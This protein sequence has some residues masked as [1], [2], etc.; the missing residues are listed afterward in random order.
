MKPQRLFSTAVPVFQRAVVKRPPLRIRPPIPPTVNN[1]EVSRDHPLWQFFHD[2]KYLR[3]YEDLDK[4]G[5]PWS[6]PELRK[7]SFDDLH[8]LWYTCLKERNILAREIQV[9]NAE[10]DQIDSEFLNHSD[11]VRETMWRIR[12][13]L[14]ERYHAQSNARERLFENE[15]KLLDEF[16]EFYLKGTKDEESEIQEALTRLQYALFGI[17]EVIEENKV[18]KHFIKGLK[19][20]AN[21]KINRYAT[22]KSILPIQDAGEAFIIFHA[23][24]NTESIK[25]S[26]EA[27]LK[28]RADGISIDKYSE[29]DTIKEYLRR[30]L[31][32]E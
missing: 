1:I 29:I 27:V 6:I 11:Q 23:E 14:S 25:E 32:S 21:L 7:K 15:E 30:V 12:H 28:L 2:G 26:I 13:V 16:T 17:S 4:A 20:I 8:S 24:P 18:D 31:E 3:S 22:N 5:R 10:T 9:L 19:Y